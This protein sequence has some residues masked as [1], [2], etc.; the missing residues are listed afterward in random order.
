MKIGQ[1]VN[2]SLQAAAQG[3]KLMKAAGHVRMK[4]EMAHDVRYAASD[5]AA[6]AAA[7]FRAVGLAD[8]RAAI[9]AEVLVEGDLMGH[10]T[11][12]LQLLPRHLEAIKS[13][14]VICQ[15]DP[16]IISDHGSALTWDGRYLPGPWLVREAMTIAFERMAQVPV[17]TVVIR[18]AGHIG[19]LAAYPRHAIEHNLMMLL[20]SSDPAVRNVAP[21]GSAEP[22]Y[23]PNPI[24][25]GWPTGGDPIIIDTCP[26]TTTGGMVARLKRAHARFPGAWLIDRR[27]QPSD[28]PAVVG[29]LGGGAILPLGGTDLGH[30]GFALAL[31]VEALTSALGGYGRAD[32]VIQDG[33]AVFLQ[34]INPNL[35]GGLAQF[36]RETQWLAEACVTS[37]PNA[38][39][40]PVR[41]PGARGLALRKQQLTE[42]VVLHPETISVLDICAAQ[43]GIPTPQPTGA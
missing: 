22:R 1:A 27:G 18:K 41:M 43:L 42:G 26:S 28:D 2:V 16:E 29:E 4:F 21:H 5:L 3:A 15:G 7:L 39:G 17:M 38:G 33:A 9:I 31:I 10:S 25:A 40:P 20:M 24:A 30:K 8:D 19:C 23:T 37:T 36:R 14:A 6:F 13:G 34:M 12:G 35:F 11:H 32:D